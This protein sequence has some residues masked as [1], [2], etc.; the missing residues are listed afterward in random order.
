MRNRLALGSTALTTPKGWQLT[1]VGALADQNSGEVQTGPFGS[2]LHSY[3]YSTGGTPVVMPQDLVG[4]KVSIRNVARVSSDHVSRLSRHQVAVDDIL[5]SRRGDVTRFAIMT[6]RE[7]GWL[8]GTGCMR[9]RLNSSDICP[10]YLSH[11]LRHRTVCDWLEFQAKGATM[12]NLNTTI[13][14]ALPLLM[15][16]LSEQKRI[17]GILDQAD[18]LRRKRQQALALTDQFLRSTFLDLFGNPITNPKQWPLSRLSSLG[19]WASGGTPP[20]SQPQYFEGNID[21][22]SAGELNHRRLPPSKERVSDAAIGVS[23]ARLFKEGTL[24]VGMYDTAA[25]KLGILPRA[26]SSNQACANLELQESNC[27][28]DWLF[29]CLEMM[30]PYFLSQRRGVRQKNLTLQMIKDF[31]IPL[32]PV[33]AQREFVTT[34]KA[35]EIL[36]SRLVSAGSMNESFFNALVQRAFRGEL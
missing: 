18:G 26:A 11:Y 10:R 8:C 27:E 29:N 22:Y 19:H 16:P 14:R 33:N 7:E 4:G 20:R 25:F 6:G 28:L 31:E 34:V 36:Q 24:L 35:V 5:Y 13:L 2:Q 32:P 30:R 12:P 9:I 15:P 23:G 1:T 21:W 3:D 17:A